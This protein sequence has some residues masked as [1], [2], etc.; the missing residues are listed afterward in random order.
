MGQV[1]DDIYLPVSRTDLA[2]HLGMTL[3]S[4]SRVVSRMVKAGI[5]AAGKD[6]LVIRSMADLALICDG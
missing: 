1:A 4:L 5:V 3:E 2:N 6:R